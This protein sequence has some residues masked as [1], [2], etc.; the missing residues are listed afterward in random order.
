M[1]FPSARAARR[2]FAGKPDKLLSIESG[3]GDFLAW[4]CRLFCV[5]Q[6]VKLK[7]IWD[8]SPMRTRWTEL[9]AYDYR[10]DQGDFW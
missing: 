5:S 10:D 1:A 3:W 2:Y 7:P 9:D 4:A 6:F 8:F